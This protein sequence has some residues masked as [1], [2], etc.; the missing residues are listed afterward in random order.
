MQPG[1]RRRTGTLRGCIHEHEQ[2]IGVR[3]R[4]RFQQD[5]IDDGEDRRVGPDTKGQ[6]CHRREGELGLC[7]NVRRQYV[8]SCQTVSSQPSIG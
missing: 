2:A 8:T 4:Q 5:L 1:G 7:R 6:R 3:E